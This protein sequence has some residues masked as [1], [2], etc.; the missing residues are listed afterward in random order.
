MIPLK[1]DLPFAS[2]PFVTIFLI[3]SC[4]CVF[5]WQ[6]S[7]DTASSRQAAAALAA[8]PAVLLPFF[9]VALW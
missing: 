4:A 6:H 2:K 7:L 9:F 3:V 5:L 1:D 8:V